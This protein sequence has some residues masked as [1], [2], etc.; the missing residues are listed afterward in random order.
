[1]SGYFPDQPIVKGADVIYRPK[2]NAG[3]YAPLA[4]NPWTGLRPRLQILLRPAGDAHRPGCSTSRRRPAPR[5]I[6]AARRDRPPP[7]RYPA[8][9]QRAGLH[10]VLQRPVPPRRPRPDAQGHARAQGRRACVLHALEGRRAAR[11]RIWR[12]TAPKRDAFAATLTTLDDAFS[13]KWEP[14]AALPGSAHRAL[15]LSISRHLHVGVAGA[16]ARRRGFAPTSSG[17]R[18]SFVDLYKVGKANYL[19]EITRTTDWADYTVRVVDLLTS[20]GKKFYIKKD[21]QPFLPAGVDNPLRIPQ[22]H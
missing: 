15:R 17:S 18:R 16:D 12:S 20:L 13:R 11:C 1:M 6:G 8:D 2:G 9:P 22:H 19:K 14:D 21:L 4:T 7:R 5:T 3:E 10:H